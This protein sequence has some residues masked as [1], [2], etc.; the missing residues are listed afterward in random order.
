MCQRRRGGRKLNFELALFNALREQCERTGLGVKACD[1]ASFQTLLIAVRDA[2]WLMAQCRP[3]SLDVPFMWAVT[4]AHRAVPR[5][6][7]E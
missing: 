2:L 1:V 4:Q 6:R 3:G 7:F 5:R